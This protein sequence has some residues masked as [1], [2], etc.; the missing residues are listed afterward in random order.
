MAWL[1]AALSALKS[2]DAARGQKGRLLA[3]FSAAL[4]A[5]ISQIIDAGLA[6]TEVFLVTDLMADNIAITALAIA[7]FGA[8]DMVAV[9][10]VDFPATK[11]LD[12]TLAQADVTETLASLAAVFRLY[13][14]RQKLK[15]F[16]P[17]ARFLRAF[18]VGW[19]R[20]E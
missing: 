13:A 2:R 9:T 19:R 4:Q 6:M 8:T 11:A 15:I 1:Q 7:D 20:N 5:R 10:A 3:R 18:F 16:P 17:E 14:S 12:I